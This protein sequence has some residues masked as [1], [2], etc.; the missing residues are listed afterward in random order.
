ME[1]KANRKMGKP[2]N[3]TQLINKLIC[4]D[5]PYTFNGFSGVNIDAKIKRDMSK[6]F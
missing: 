1:A 4:L 2:F 5:K 3:T 6:L